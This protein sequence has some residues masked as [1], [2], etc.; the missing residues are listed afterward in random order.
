MKAWRRLLHR[1]L[2]DPENCKFVFLSESCVPLRPLDE[3]YR[4]LVSNDASYINY[5]TPWWPPTDAREV[6][7]LP[8]ENRWVNSEW[9]ILNR[10]HA[11]LMVQDNSVLKN[12]EH[13]PHSCEAYPACLLSYYGHLQKE[14]VINKPTTH[15]DFLRGVE[16][17]PYMFQEATS[18]NIQELCK[19]RA[20]GLLFARK[21]AREF[22]QDVLL[23][24]IY[25]K[26][27]K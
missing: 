16:S 3:I 15:V 11:I 19:A 24:I 14:D 4:L 26:T 13:F 18:F 1:A 20:D 8:K 17:H 10:K 25:D 21:I 22:P 27:S 7:L 23:Q 6:V 5:F 12:V 9:I 2:Q